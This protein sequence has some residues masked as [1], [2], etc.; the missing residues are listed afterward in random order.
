MITLIF[1][2]TQKTAK[3]SYTEN[4]S[5]TTHKYENITTVKT[6]NSSPANSSGVPTGYYELMQKEGD[7]TRP[8]LRLPVANT[9]MFIDC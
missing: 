4:S 3:V 9:I 1:N 8:I 2:T 5:L 7:K 6:D